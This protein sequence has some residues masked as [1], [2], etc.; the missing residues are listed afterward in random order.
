[1]SGNVLHNVFT[2]NYLNVAFVNSGGCLLS[3]NLFLDSKIADINNTISVR[4]ED[5]WDSL[6][7]QIYNNLFMYSPMY[8]Q[9][10]EPSS[11]SSRYMN[12]NKYAI[13]DESSDKRFKLMKQDKTKLDYGWNEWIDLWKNLNNGKN[14][15]QNSTRWICD[16]ASATVFN[17]LKIH[18]FTVDNVKDRIVGFMDKIFPFP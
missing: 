16:D 9:L 11:V 5:K 6:N 7:V 12:N 18:E 8:L 1:M 4:N 13:S 15:D 3:Y 14:G 2:G 10:T 17:E